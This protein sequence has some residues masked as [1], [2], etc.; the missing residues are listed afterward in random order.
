LASSDER[1]SGLETISISATPGPVE[2]DVAHGRVLVVDRLAGVLLEV[3]ALDAHLD[4]LELA[5]DR[6]RR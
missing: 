2:V 6:R 4:I 5:V 1:R 3:Q